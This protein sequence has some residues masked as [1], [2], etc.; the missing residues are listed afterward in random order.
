[1]D[2]EHPRR[3]LPPAPSSAR[4]MLDSQRS[5]A[6][7]DTMFPEGERR[8]RGLINFVSRFQGAIPDAYEYLRGGTSLELSEHIR[9]KAISVLTGNGDARPFDWAR[10]SNHPIQYALEDLTIS[11]GGGKGRREGVE[12][13]KSNPPQETKARWSWGRK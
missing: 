4:E 10:V 5:K 9:S 1:M 12:M 3:E 13:S 6:G 2:D 11:M 8:K 7:F